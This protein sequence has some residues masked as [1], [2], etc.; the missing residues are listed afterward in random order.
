LLEAVR[1][2][3]RKVQEGK[4]DGGVPK[5]EWL[6]VTQAGQVLRPAPRFQR[7]D[8]PPPAIGK[9]LTHPYR[10]EA[11]IEM[12]SENDFFSVER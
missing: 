3:H 2:R 11:F 12:L 1:K 10:I 4:L 8:R 9:V 7:L 6:S 5:S